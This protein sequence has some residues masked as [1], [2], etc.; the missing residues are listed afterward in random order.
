MAKERKRK[1]QE[2]KQDI[3]NR[4]NINMKFNQLLSNM[5]NFLASYKEFIVATQNLATIA[6]IFDISVV[7]ETCTCWYEIYLAIID[8]Y[9]FLE[10]GKCSRKYHEMDVDY[11]FEKENSKYSNW[12]YDTINEQNNKL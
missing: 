5:N 3:D 8:E 4:P 9:I 12:G 2:I 7:K 10:T 1:R 11:I 6:C